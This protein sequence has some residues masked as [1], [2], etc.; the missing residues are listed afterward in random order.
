MQLE[1]IKTALDII[2]IHALETFP[3]ECCGFMFGHDKEQRKITECRSVTNSQE[4]DRR[5]RFEISP[6]EYLR[7][8]KYA[9]E[10]NLE[11]LGIYHSHPLHPAKPSE[12]DRVQAIGFFSYVITSVFQKDIRDTTS[13][14]LND[15][16]Q[17]DQEILQLVEQ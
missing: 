10:N 1:I 12:H 8:E 7:A 13:W 4:G 11:L 9:L 16:R 17:F 2:H 6:V 3:N 5:R 14:R 15:Q